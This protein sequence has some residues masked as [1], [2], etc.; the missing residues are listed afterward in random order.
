MKTIN[1][2]I[3]A[4][5]F[6]LN[7]YSQTPGV[8]NFNYTSLPKTSSKYS[9]KHVLA[10]WIETDAGV[11]VKT[12]KLNAEG[13][14]EYLYTWNT[15]SSGNTTDATTG[16]TLSNHTSHNLSWD[17]TGTDGILVPDGNYKIITEFTSEHAQ[18]PL[19]EVS[20]SKTVDEISLQPNDETYFNAISLS[21]VP[22]STTSVEN[23]LHT[24]GLDIY[25]NPIT[26]NF[27]IQFNL[28]KTS[29]I[30]VSVY[31]SKM[32]LME[33]I[34]SG[35]KEKGEIELSFT[36][37]DYNLSQGIYYILVKS[38][39]FQSARKIIVSN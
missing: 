9:P 20:F 21:F 39:T 29:D 19:L 14:K 18:G 24:I 31:D 10:T 11:F 16:A 30:K 33:N 7:T 4:I 25:P 26:D 13:R 1:I 15:R 36:L 17:I 12:L 27:T 38:D 5:L 2:L 3:I 8:L 6:S 34:Y 28:T 22:E 23:Q 35:H 32:S 37:N